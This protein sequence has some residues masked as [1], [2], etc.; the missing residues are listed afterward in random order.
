MRR[1]LLA[2]LF[3]VVSATN[4]IMS[5]PYVAQ[6]VS[7]DTATKVGQS[8]TSIGSAG[9]EDSTFALAGSSFSSYF[10][11]SSLP[12]TNYVRSIL[13]LSNG[14]MLLAATDG[15]V[16]AVIKVDPDGNQITFSNLITPSDAVKTKMFLDRDGSL[17]VPSDSNAPAGNGGG[18]VRRYNVTTGAHD[19]NFDVT[20]NDDDHAELDLVGT[21]AQQS[22]G[23]ILVSGKKDNLGTIIAYNSVDGSLDDSFG[24]NGIYQHDKAQAIWDIA[25]DSQ[26]RIYFVYNN[27]SS[28]TWVKR[29]DPDGKSVD[30]AFDTSGDA[31]SNVNTN[32]NTH[33]ALDAN[34][35]IVM[36]TVNDST[37]SAVITLFDKDDGS[38]I[39]SALTIVNST[40][41]PTATTHNI[42]LNDLVL[43]DAGK[44]ILV[45]RINMTGKPF[46]VR[47]LADLSAIDATFNTTGAQTA[48]SGMT[49]SNQQW[50]GVVVAEDG[51][52]Y[53]AGGN[54]SNPYMLR[55]YGDQYVAQHDASVTAGIA[56]TLD[57]TL[58][59]SAVAT[60]D[61]TGAFDLAT[62]DAVN[63]ADTKPVAVTAFTSGGHLIAFDAGSSSKIVRVDSDNSLNTL[64]NSGGATPGVAA[65]LPSG[66]KAMELDGAS[67]IV[68]TGNDGSTAWVQ[69]NILL[70]EKD[71][72]FDGDGLVE[73]ADSAFIPSAIREQ[74]YARLLVAGYDGTNTT[75]AIYAFSHADGSLDTTFGTNGVASIGVDATIAGMAVDTYNRIIVVYK[76]STNLELARLLPHGSF[77]SAFGT[78]GKVTTLSSIT[79]AANNRVVIDAN[80]DIVVAAVSGGSVKVR[81]YNNDAGVAQYAELDL[82]LSNVAG[83][84]EL[85]A[86][87]NGTV[88]VSG[89]RSGNNEMFVARVTNAG[90]LDTEF[91]PLGSIQGV[92]DFTVEND[93]QTARVNNAAAVRVDGRISVVG[94]ED[95]GTDNPFLARIYAEPYTLAVAQNPSYKSEGLSDEGLIGAIMDDQNFYSGK[96]FYLETGSDEDSLN[97]RPRVVGMIDNNK[98]IVAVDGQSS[99]GDS[100]SKMFIARFDMDGQ[101]D[102]SFDSN[103]WDQLTHVYG[104]EYVRAMHLFTDGGV[105]KAILGGYITS[106]SPLNTTLSMLVQYSITAAAVDSTFGG[107]HAD[108]TGMVIGDARE[109]H[110]VARQSQG[111][112]IAAGLDKGGS[113]AVYRY[114]HDGSLDTTFGTYGKFQVESSGNGL[115][116]FVV[117]EQDRM[118]M[119]YDDNSG[120]MEVACLLSDGSGLDANFGT[121]GKVASND[122]IANVGASEKAVVALDQDGKIIVAAITDSNPG[123]SDDD[124]VTV[125]RYHVDGSKDGNAL[126]V[127]TSQLDSTLVSIAKIIIDKD[128]K[129]YLFLTN[130]DA[131]DDFIMIRILADMSALDDTLNPDGD[132]PG[133][134]DYRVRSASSARVLQDAYLH[135]DGRI[136]VVG[137]EE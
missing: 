127:T 108:A 103:G 12:G 50:N 117:D 58:D 9:T 21:I 105:Q 33:I 114:N 18:Q 31:V 79:D 125:Q 23:R 75:G 71:Q 63:L 73:F 36:A 83:L 48:N 37:D 85:V 24:V 101:L 25:V 40:I 118:I 121:N 90:A 106:G 65:N 49:G 110:F 86:V 99:A 7:D 39:G 22:S 98:Y 74:T 41:E 62:L 27:D 28:S 51:R 60:T 133:R 107:I 6:V 61:T 76:N 20:V 35:N 135:D 45:G 46:V 29:L 81:K 1:F 68:S 87:S 77:D 16:S 57:L 91:N 56:G 64:F 80:G 100:A 47:V 84:T 97:Q 78:A 123:T 111:R 43:D 102:T 131:D 66:I 5:D 113:G 59:Q 4:I 95:N 72:T 104:N 54:A 129:I 69:R 136:I 11:A 55:L 10:A 82:G 116:S 115:Y 15:G 122:R 19:T 44:V 93:A 32:A 34:E 17:L 132:E 92:L 8:T 67:N 13:R 130:N 124:Q 70:G 119:V 128:N 38:V 126:V 112:I 52:I 120:N 14:D 109:F 26:D 30:G 96:L 89:Y 3:L 42:D 2:T 53:A 134:F 88:L 94:Y 137:S